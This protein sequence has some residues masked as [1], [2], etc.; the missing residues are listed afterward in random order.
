[1]RKLTQ[2]NDGTDSTS[3]MLFWSIYDQFRKCMHEK[4][5]FTFTRSVDNCGRFCSLPTLFRRF[6]VCMPAGKI[7]AEKSFFFRFTLFILND[8][9]TINL[10]NS[11]FI[12]TPMKNTWCM[13]PLI[14]VFISISVME[15]TPHCHTLCGMRIPLLERIEVFILLK[16]YIKHSI[17]IKIW[18]K[19]NRSTST[20]FALLSHI[21][22][23]I[24]TALLIRRATLY[25]IV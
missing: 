12:A 18:T 9:P 22:I 10:F 5:A 15:R 25:S 3:F 17:S 24:N 7:S 21:I 13:Y 23:H 1:M 2:H 8:H 20:G 11:V 16:N 14:F 4:F 19:T 6:S